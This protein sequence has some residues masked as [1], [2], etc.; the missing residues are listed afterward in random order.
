VVLRR[1]PGDPAPPAYWTKGDKASHKRMATVG[2]VYSVER[3]VRTPE[4]VVAALFRD[5]PCPEVGRPWPRH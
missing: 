5:G 2:T 1:G 4:Q 3:Y